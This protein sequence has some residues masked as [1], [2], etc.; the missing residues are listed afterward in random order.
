MTLTVF[1]TPEDIAAGTR[2]NSHRCPV[3]IAVRRALHDH[4]PGKAR[5]AY[6]CSAGARAITYG[7]RGRIQTI[8]PTAAVAMWIAQFDQKPEL[9]H[10]NLSFQIQAP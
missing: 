10:E 1:V 6:M 9:K 3:A 7:I 4:E 8:K 5:T 2:G